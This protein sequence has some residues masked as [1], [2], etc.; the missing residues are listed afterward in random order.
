MKGAGIRIT[1]L[2]RLRHLLGI[3]KAILFTALTRG[4][5]AFGGIATV[6]LILTFLTKEEQGYY[7]TFGSILALQIFFELGFTAIITQYVAHEAAHLSWNEEGLLQ[8]EKIY[9]SRLSSLLKFSVKWYFIISVIL[10]LILIISGG[11]FFGKFGKLDYAAWLIPWMVL[12]I[13]T[14]CLLF[15]NPL[16]AFLE[17]LGKIK[18]VAQIRL[19]QQFVN[20]VLVWGVLLLHGKLYAGGVGSLF[21]FLLLAGFLW[22]GKFRKLLTVIWNS[23]G[24]EK[25]DYKKE[26]FP[27]QFR[28]ALSWVASY[29]IFQLFN[30]V[31]FAYEGAVVA[32]QMG[33]TLSVL[34]NV[35]ALSVSW[36]STKIPL[37]SGYIARRE[38]AALD[39]S[40]DRTL[41]QSSFIN[42]AGLIAL[43]MLVVG[44]RSFGLK[45]ADRILPY[46]PL[47]ML[48]V[49]L[50]FNNL[51][52]GWATYLRCHKREPFL[53][54]SIVVG[55]LCGASTLL[56][57]KYYGVKGVTTGYTFITVFISAIWALNLFI[58][59]KKLW[60]EV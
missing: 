41:K 27:Y 59:N 54:Q 32:G 42:L 35:L 37:W 25:V 3:D 55:V 50:F 52:N 46:F 6:S 12:S 38:Y 21:S 23:G 17:G 29:F 4:V 2:G 60:H 49:S 30:P 5:Q 33:L 9:L 18:D 14:S 39:T 26:I 36:V 53:Y 16:L 10:S 28:M 40:F 47:V 19:A 1:S 8:G 51:I 48:M 45:I 24:P 22:F 13:A 7:Y 57:G 43:F 56:L 44:L 15:I 34:N 20:M 31:L 58:K 11:L